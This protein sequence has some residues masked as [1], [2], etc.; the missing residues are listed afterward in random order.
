LG[1]LIGGVEP[2]AC[3]TICC[4]LVDIDPADVPIIRTA[5]QMSFGC[6]DFDKIEITGDDFPENVCTDFE[7]PHLIPLR[8]SLPHVCKSIAK[9]I[10]LLAKVKKTK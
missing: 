4:K 3:E 7:L 5:R 1:W 8:F 10:L 9:Q 6:S 2:I